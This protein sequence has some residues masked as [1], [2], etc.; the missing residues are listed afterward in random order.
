[1][2]IWVSTFW[3]L[4]IIL[5]WTFMY[6]FLCGHMFSFPL[7][8]YLRVELLGH[9]ITLCLTFWGITRPFSKMAAPF[10]IP[11]AMYEGSNFSETSP[12]LVIICLF[13]YSHPSG[14]DLMVVCIFLMTS[15]A[16]HFSWAY[17]PFIYLFWR[18]GYSD[19]LLILKLGYLSLHYC[20][21]FSRARLGLTSPHCFK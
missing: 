5:L 18:N 20:P 13:G 4:W 19:P 10:H 1:M 14:C 7:G 15:D 9:M 8:T 17:W 3:L 11:S 2:D 12:T 16:E 6:K 21:L